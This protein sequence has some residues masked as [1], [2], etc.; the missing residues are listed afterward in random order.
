M[1]LKQSSSRCFMGFFLPLLTSSTELN[2]LQV[3]RTRDAMKRFI[4]MVSEMQPAITRSTECKCHFTFPKS[5][6][7]YESRSSLNFF[8]STWKPVLASQSSAFDTDDQCLLRLMKQ[9]KKLC[10]LRSQSISGLHLLAFL[11]PRGHA[12]PFPP[13][14]WPVT[15]ISILRCTL[16]LSRFLSMMLT[17]DTDQFAGVL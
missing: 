12:H 11:R 4:F 14:W 7:R 16:S 13:T 9:K 15:F 3:R 1:H 8:H 2:R 10:N 5:I 6:G 17:R